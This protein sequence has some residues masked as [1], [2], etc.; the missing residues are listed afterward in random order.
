MFYYNNRV[1]LGGM[2]KALGY[3]KLE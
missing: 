3:S 1:A 2:L